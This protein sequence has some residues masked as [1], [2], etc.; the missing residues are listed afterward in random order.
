MN[1][2]AATHFDRPVRPA[3]AGI[4]V[5]HPPLSRLHPAT[6]AI[7]AGGYLAMILTFWLGFATP[8]DHYLPLVIFGLVLAAFIGVPWLIA[9]SAQSFWRRHEGGPAEPRFVSF[10]QFLK[11]KVETGGGTVSGPET[12]VL[13]ALIPIALTVAL[14]AMAVIMHVIY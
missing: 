1:T 11:S 13:M 7:T 2:V 9:R 5:Q 4:A 8:T 12:L 3:A 10:G 14:I 6:I